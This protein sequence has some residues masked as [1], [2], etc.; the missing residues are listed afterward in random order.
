M[1]HLTRSQI[2]ARKTGK[3]TATLLDGSTVA[4]RA[5]TRDEVIEMQEM[6][7][8]SDRDNFII[9]TGMTN[10]VLTRDDVAVWA[11]VADAGDLVA[12]SDAV[13][14]LSGL[15]KGAGKSGVAGA[16]EQS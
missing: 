1:A 7:S 10:P 14:E 5:L 2:L 15:K 13:A 16:G 4:I 8:L 12:V 6:E 3:G 9:A 11:G